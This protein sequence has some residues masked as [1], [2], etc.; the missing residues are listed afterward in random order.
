MDPGIPPYGTD[1]C[2]LFTPK[3]YWHR[4]RNAMV[5]VPTACS[6]L[7]LFRSGLLFKN[8]LAEHTVLRNL[9]HIPY[10]KHWNEALTSLGLQRILVYD[11]HYAG[12]FARKG[13][14]SRVD[15]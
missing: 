14:R 9:L 6:V 12:L 7:H 4:H 8:L 2:I 3:V 15:R 11:P 13:A 1:R 5:R 10:P